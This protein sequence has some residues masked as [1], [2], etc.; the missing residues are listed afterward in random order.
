MTLTLEARDATA[1]TPVLIAALDAT[2]ARARAGMLYGERLRD[3]RI[4][5][6]AD[7]ERLPL[8]TREDLQRA[9]VH[10]TRAVPL[11]QV[12]HYGESSGTSGAA[13]AMWLTAGDLVRN[14]DAIRATHPDV[15]AAGRMLLNRFPFMAAPAH[16]IQLVAQRGGGVSIPAG[17]INWDVPFPRAL[18]L[19][20]TTGVQVLAGLP[21]EPI[22]FEAIARERGL[23]PAR[24]FAFDTFFLGG[25]TLPPAMRRRMARI[26]GVRVIELYGSTET[27]LL[28][29][30][31]TEGAVH[32]ETGLV[33]CEILRLDRSRPADA[34]EEGL[35]VV[36][37][38]GIE[39]S[40]LV[41]LDTGDLVRRLGPCACGDPRPSLTVLGRERETL[42]VA[43]LRL[44]Q[45]TLVDAA[46]EAADVLDS[47]VFFTV[48]LPDRVIVRVETAASTDPSAAL[49]ARLGG[50]PVEVERVPRGMLLDTELLGRSPHVYK[51]VVVGDW[52][53]P[54]RRILNVVEGMIEW[55]RPTLPEFWRW[56]RRMVATERRRRALGRH[57]RVVGH[58]GR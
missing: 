8:T 53:G 1:G 56:A 35:L 10:G 32:L 25:S 34:G 50:V 42:D 55:P 20:R 23:D 27:M 43:G 48:V 36:T 49:A 19:A 5:S 33:H 38:I 15:F 11:E 26:W 41:R 39:G 46:A 28:G 17:N 30:S 51:P 54:G 22:V 7:L 3:V 31:C 45:H 14:A 24:D 58:R 16:L 47:S 21:L 6:L 4:R 57:A 37:T 9:G 18:E 12:C 2:V 13:N 40:P 44:H 52:R 29:T